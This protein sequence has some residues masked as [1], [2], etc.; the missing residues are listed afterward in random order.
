M[1]RAG[2]EAILDRAAELLPAVEGTFNATQARASAVFGLVFLE[3]ST[4][5]RLSFETAKSYTPPRK[6]KNESRCVEA[7]GIS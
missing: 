3:D 6:S 7:Y 1:E 5:T 2:V 4:R